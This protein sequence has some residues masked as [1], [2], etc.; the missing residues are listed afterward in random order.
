MFFKFLLQGIVQNCLTEENSCYFT[1]TQCG[2][3]YDFTISSF[4]GSCQSD[5]SSTVGIR[6]GKTK[7]LLHQ[8][9]VGNFSKLA[10]SVQECNTFKFLYM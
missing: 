3:H 4:S 2:L 10:F 6:T 5:F 1:N 8:N 7:Y 9:S